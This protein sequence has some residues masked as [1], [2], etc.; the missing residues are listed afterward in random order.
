MAASTTR[1]RRSPMQ[2]ERSPTPSFHRHCPY[3]STNSSTLLPDKRTNRWS[4]RAKPRRASASWRRCTKPLETVSGRNLRSRFC[5]FST[6]C[7]KRCWSILVVLLSVGGWCIGAA[8]RAEARQT[9][10][11]AVSR[12]AMELLKAECFACHNEEKKK[13]RLVLT[14]REALLKGNDEGVVVVPGKPDS[15]RLTRALLADADPHMPPKKQL[16]D[17]QIQVLRDWIKG[18]LVWDAK[19]LAEAEANPAPVELAALPASYQPVIALALSP[20]G[21]RLAVGRGGTVVVHDAS[22]TNF[23]VLAQLEAH[24]DAIQAM[25]WSP[26]GRWLASGAFRR[27][28]LWDIASFKLEREWTNGLAGRVTGIQF[29]PDGKALAL[30]EGVTGQ[31]GFLRLIDTTESKIGASW[32][33][34]GDTIYGMDFS[35]DGTQLVTAG[36]DKLIKVWELAS[37]KELARLEGHT[38]QV[39]SVAFNT[40]ATQVV[41]GG[42]DKEIRV[43]DIRTREK[44]VSLGSHSAGVTSVAWPGDGKVILAATDGG[45]V[46]SYTNL[47]VHTG[48]QSSNGGDEKKIGDANETVLCI[49][50]T[51]DG[52]T[53][54]AG[55]H[56]GVVHVWNSER[57]LLAKLMPATNMI[58]FSAAPPFLNGP[59]KVPKLVSSDLKSVIQ[60]AKSIRASSR[61]LLQ[62]GSIMSLTAEPKEIHLSADAPQHGVLISAQTADGFDVDITDRVGFSPSRRAPFEVREKGELRALRPGAGTLIASFGRRHIEIPIRIEARAIGGSDSS[63]VFEPPPVSFLRDVLPALS[64]AGCNAGACHAKAEGQNGFKLSVFSYDPKSDYAHIVKDARGR[65]VSPAAPDESLIIKKPTATIPHEGGLRFERGSETHQLLARWLRE[66]MAYSVTNEPALQRLVVFPKERRYRKGATQRL[67]VQAHYSDGSVREVTRLAAF[68]SN[69]KETATVDEH[70]V[71]TVGTLTGQ[72]VVVARYAGLVADAHIMVPAD[73]VLPEAQYAASPHYNF[74]DGLAY[75]QFQRLG[76]LPSELC[77]DAEFLR[78]ASLDAIGVLPTPDEARE[79]LNP[80]SSRGNE[81]HDFKSEIRNPK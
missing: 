3:R 8:P 26:D 28:V 50:T 68:D 49:A 15:S 51:P 71:V 56:D 9:A 21:K 70:G 69:D 77:N 79:F 52:K 81:A 16:T 23:P 78:R 4:S 40:N 42:T 80:R 41:S 67:L 5:N 44:I 25:A 76:L 48:E 58:A 73:R 53:I 31:S 7:L 29:A 2:P 12:K 17:A 57:E 33:A 59:S 74:I 61:R 30:A 13:G 27:L 18:G 43:W 20:D 54:F 24:R 36:G 11:T 1:T 10:G 32:R 39:L 35:R 64:K 55:S 46:S 6:P 60:D 38:A 45:V 63:S 37:G 65:R 22:Q 47:K 34:H 19:A 72:G 14:S 62:T 75:A 66:G